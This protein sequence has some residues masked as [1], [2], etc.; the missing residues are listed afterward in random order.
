MSN[1]GHTD[2][3]LIVY[4]MTI[5]HAMDILV[6]W[7]TIY[8]KAFKWHMEIAVIGGTKNQLRNI[9]DRLK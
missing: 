3:L 7:L 4:L 8:S 9:Q 1:I 5:G 6:I 2:D